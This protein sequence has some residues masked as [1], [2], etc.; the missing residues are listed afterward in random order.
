[1][2]SEREKVAKKKLKE[3]S[4][5]KRF[6]QNL[7]LFESRPKITSLAASPKDIPK[8]EAPSSSSSNVSISTN[9]SLEIDQLTKEFFISVSLKD[10]DSIEAVVVGQI[11][12]STWLIQVDVSFSILWKILGSFCGW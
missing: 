4:M 5:F 8:P 2:Y 3:L 7:A 6:Q 1:M 10:K 11:N 9:D 12:R